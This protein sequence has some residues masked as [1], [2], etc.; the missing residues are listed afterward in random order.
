M[1]LFI[2][3]RPSLGQRSPFSF[4][5]PCAHEPVS[6]GEPVLARRLGAGQRGI[7]QHP[8]RERTDAVARPG[9]GSVVGL[10][11]PRQW[12]GQ[13]QH[14]QGQM[15]SPAQGS[16]IRWSPPPEDW[17]TFP[18]GWCSPNRNHWRSI[19]NADVTWRVWPRV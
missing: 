2:K 15:E 12:P 7:T 18:K 8:E 14:G 5:L 6:T 10:V 11:L 9:P 13:A 1:C 4:L 16:V 17:L 3:S 19:H